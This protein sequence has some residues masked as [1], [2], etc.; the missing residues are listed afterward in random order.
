MN[1]KWLEMI[2]L[3]GGLVVALFGAFMSIRQRQ[4]EDKN[5]EAKA[6]VDA[7][8]QSKMVQDIAIDLQNTY[9][10]RVQDNVSLLEAELIR[11]KRRLSEALG[12]KEIHHET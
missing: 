7:V 1:S 5:N 6:G 11:T 3:G 12:E 9:L 4:R 10:Q 2:S 8:A